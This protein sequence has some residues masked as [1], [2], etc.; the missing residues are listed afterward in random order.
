MITLG[1]SATLSLSF[2][3][4][5]PQTDPD[6]PSVPNL[7]IVSSGTSTRMTFVNGVSSSTV[8]YNFQVVPT[9]P[10][11]YTIPAII[12]QVGNQK[13]VSQPLS[14]KVLKP[15]PPS[16]AAVNSGGQLAFIKLT[17]PKKQMYVGET[18][19]AQL[20]LYINGSR[21]Q[22]TGGFQT[23]SF[24][25]DGFNMGK[26]VQGQ[27]RQ[28]QIGRAIY[29][30]YPLYFTLRATKPGALSIGP[31]AAE[32]VVEL[33][34][35][36]RQRDFLDPFGMFSRGE[37]RKVPLAT[38]AQNVQVLPVPRENAPPSFNGAV[39]SYTMSM[40]AGP[41]NVAVGEPIT[42]RIQIS[43]RG[44]PDSL[45]L[46]EQPEWHDFNT[47][48][49][50]SKVDLTD[51]LGIQGT[52]SFELVVAPQHTDTKALPPF[53]FSFFDPDQKTFRTLTHPGVPLIVRPGGVA[54]APTAVTTIHNGQDTPPPAQDIVPNKQRLGTVAQIGLPLFQ[55]RWFLS[56]Q[57][58]PVLAFVF[59]VLWRRRADKLANSPRL[60]R[61]RKV[62]H[63][64]R[65]GLGQLRQFAELKKSEEFFA[66]LMRLLQEQ[67]G[68]RLDLPASAITEAV[69]D[70]RL[71][72]VG[73]PE[74]ALV[75]LQELFQTCNLARYAPI[76]TS[77]ELAAL[78][79]KLEA[80]L[81]ELRKVKA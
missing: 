41:T 81:G 32:I 50:T 47:Y 29:N 30:H 38:E 23:T 25:A 44:W 12:V 72:P 63:I 45:T 67:L 79:P 73:V 43:G 77:Q 78:I 5:Q 49:P 16:A 4:G 35:P 20:D 36:N 18:V 66:L 17:L 39:G 74:T 11:D 28:E 15:T 56:L 34:T 54:A 80:V 55:Q 65:Q 68:E 2:E 24:A 3:G 76:K 71:R 59:S 7:Q 61:Q 64:I 62:A 52:K 57:A 46:P 69:I 53:S 40:S 13:L 37:Q 6:I 21:V 14:L 10:G 75:S 33:P 42:V 26:L 60:R 22:R 27:G 19:M 58:I 48:P 1:E 70:E 51:S 9:Q 8:A 31:L